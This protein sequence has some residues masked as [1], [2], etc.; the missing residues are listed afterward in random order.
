[1]D[2][3]MGKYLYH[4]EIIAICVS[5]GFLTD[6][7]RYQEQCGLALVCPNSSTELSTAIVDKGTGCF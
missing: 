2:E 1:M 5:G 4:I 3:V 7:R 6:L